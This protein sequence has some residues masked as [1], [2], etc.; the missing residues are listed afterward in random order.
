MQI[1]YFNI[2]EESILWSVNYENAVLKLNSSTS[3]TYV[4]NFKN[5]NSVINF[6]IYI[7]SV[8]L[9]GLKSV[10][11]L[12]YKGVCFPNSCLEVEGLERRGKP[13]LQTEANNLQS[14][15]IFSAFTV[16]NS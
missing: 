16:A 14:T 15:S 11:L 10:L 12:Q 2:Y 9:S 4:K 7:H 13:D 1:V 8:S 5:L 6:F 3:V